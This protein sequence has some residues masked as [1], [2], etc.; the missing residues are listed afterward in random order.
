M[1]LVRIPEPS[2]HDEWLFELKLDGFR[3]M[4]FARRRTSMGT[5]AP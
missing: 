5:N 4:G 3:S 1:P 2:D